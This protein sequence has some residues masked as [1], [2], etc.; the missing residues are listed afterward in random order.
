LPHLTQK[1]HYSS[2]SLFLS[3]ACFIGYAGGL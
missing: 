3:S 1:V 2:L